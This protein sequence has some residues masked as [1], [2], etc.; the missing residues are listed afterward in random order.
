MGLYVP[1][2]VT[3]SFDNNWYRGFDTHVRK[4][5]T[6]EASIQLPDRRFAGS[7]NTS[8]WNHLVMLSFETWFEL[9]VWRYNCTQPIFHLWPKLN[10]NTKPHLPSM[11]M[12]IL[13]IINLSLSLLL[14]IVSSQL[15]EGHVQTPRVFINLSTER[16]LTMKYEYPQLSLLLIITL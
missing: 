6:K 7:D 12:S 16:W 14:K 1:F 4:T 3:R 15:A 8:K 10:V 9:L 13:H 5:S 2:P 11:K